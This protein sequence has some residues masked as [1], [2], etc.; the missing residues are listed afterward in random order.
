MAGRTSWEGGFY[1]KF[2]AEE[3]SMRIIKKIVEEMGFWRPT[4]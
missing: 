4:K 1:I 3:K 2:K